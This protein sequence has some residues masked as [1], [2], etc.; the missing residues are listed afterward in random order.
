MPMS[1]R[2]PSLRG[3]VPA[4]ARSARASHAENEQCARSKLTY[5]T[6]PLHR[7]STTAQVAVPSEVRTALL[8]VCNQVRTKLLASGY[9]DPG[10]GVSVSVTDLVVSS[11]EETTKKRPQGRAPKGCTWEYESGQWIGDATEMKIHGMSMED[12]GKRIVRVDLK[13]PRKK[14]VLWHNKGGVMKQAIEEVFARHGNVGQ[15]LKHLQD[16]GPVL[17]KDL[18]PTTLASWYQR[19]RE[20]PEFKRDPEQYTNN[21]LRRGGMKSVLSKP[22]GASL[23]AALR[24][25]VASGV[26]CGS[27]LIRMRAVAALQEMKCAQD[28]LHPSTGDQLHISGC[29]GALKLSTQWLNHICLHPLDFGKA[30]TMRAATQAKYNVPDDHAAQFHQLL[31]R[32]AW[33][34]QEHSIPASNVIAGDETASLLFAMGKGKG[35]CE[36]GAK[37]NPRVGEGDKRQIT[38]MITVSL[39]G[40]MLKLQFVWGGKTVACTPWRFIKDDP[41]MN[42]HLHSSTKSHWSTPV[43]IY[44]LIEN[45][46][47]PYFI[48]QNA[49]HRRAPHAVS[50]LIWDVHYSH[51]DIGMREKMRENYGWIC[52]DF[53]PARCTGPYQPGDQPEV[54]NT[55]KTVSKQEGEI[56][57]AGK[58]TALSAKHSGTIPGAEVLKLLQKSVIGPVL[59]SFAQKGWQA[60]TPDKVKS[61]WKKTGLDKMM[62]PKIQIEAVKL[63]AEGL[64]FKEGHTEVQGQPDAFDEPESTEVRSRPLG[65]GI[66]LLRL[67]HLAF[68]LVPCS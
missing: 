52:V 38:V 35:R 63:H 42:Q 60:V 9:H 67:S 46:Y 64:L 27:T 11:H 24:E 23:M 25:S 26:R 30:L 41:A 43:S 53:I 55:F 22:Q 36:I 61:A 62:D 48:A 68:L 14:R 65:T 47:A 49:R 57:L 54:N 59:P 50:L 39:D 5:N 15:A 3:A 6:T 29:S 12:A 13:A 44:E 8:D 4:A 45:I 56:W 17:Y 28:V 37:D 66:L 7:S 2:A 21:A 33:R 20:K 16:I 34:C 40:T 1:L 51:R 19:A 32:C 10:G 58:L 31:L 18:T